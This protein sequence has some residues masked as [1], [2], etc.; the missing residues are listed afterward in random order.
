MSGTSRLEDEM[1][2]QRQTPLLELA[3]SVPKDLR[4]E[5]EIQWFEDG[6]PCGYAMAP[7]GKYLHDMADRIAELEAENEGLTKYCED[8]C[9]DKDQH[10]AIVRQKNAE[11]ERLTADN[12][13]LRAAL[14]PFADAHYAMAEPNI[15]IDPY[16]HITLYDIRDAAEA[17]A[18]V[19][20]KT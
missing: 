6:T 14:K 12:E 20:D 1:S 4:G 16:D 8:Q 19:E 2:D 7:V 15:I 10:N 9:V 17:L 3:R 11:I 5:W 13:K 18:A